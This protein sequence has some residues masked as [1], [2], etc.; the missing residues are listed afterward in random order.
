MPSKI[1]DS[2]C[3]YNLEPLESNWQAHWRQAQAEGIQASMVVGTSLTTSKRAVEI[4]AQ[5]SNLYASVGVHPH[6][7]EVDDQE[8]LKQTETGLNNLFAKYQTQIKAVG[9]TG[10]DYFR[11]ASAATTAKK[12]QQAAFKLHLHLAQT[13]HV[14][15]IIHVRDQAAP[16]TPTAGNA[17]WDTLQML[18]DNWPND[19]PFILHCASGPLNYIEQALAMGAYI[20]A[21]GNVTYKKADRIREIV[22]LTPADRLLIETDSPY[23]PPEPRRGQVCEPWLIKLTA[24]YLQETMGID[25]DQVWQNSL[26]AFNVRDAT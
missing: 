3:H 6:Q 2:H 26:R 7:F 17:Y 14:P 10:L 9:E 5:E 22:K 4:A 18:K 25:L 23:L 19:Q 13:H 12:A 11:L 21:A 1:F 24:E 8:F 20:G 16:E 15:V